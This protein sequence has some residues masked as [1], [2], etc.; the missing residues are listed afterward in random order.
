MKK[1]IL[2]FILLFTILL[3]SLPTYAVELP[4]GYLKYGSRGSRVEEV[5][6]ALNKIGYQIHEDGIYGKRT[7]ESI[8]DLQRKYNRLSM[9]GIYGANT[10]RAIEK[11]MTG[12]DL[13]TTDK[14]EEDKSSENIEPASG[15]IAYL[16]FDDGPSTTV[17]PEILDILN[18][19]DI[20]ATFFVLGT[21]AEQN[22][23]ILKRIQ[24][25]GHSIGNHTYSHKYDYLYRNMDNF[26]GELNK[27]DRILK[28]ILG[29]DFKT[30]LLRFPGGS[31]ENYK[32]KYKDKAESLGYRVYDWNA[33]NGDSES[34]GRSVESLI[35]RLK[36]TSRGQKE[37][38]VLMHDTYGK[39]NTA[40]ALPSIIDYL[41]AEGYGFGKL[42]E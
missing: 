10:R 7:R 32:Q 30:R 34:S 28:G 39:E 27:T 9:D 19:Y 21:M 5:Q 24:E 15:K 2:S 12:E 13:A 38:V 17:T 22:P 33:L 8:L 3:V 31:F 40:K 29:E 18:K 37:L 16:T 36:E 35:G 6:R 4:G 14:V 20:R 42:E 25:E 23:D 1:K 11:L 41:K 26:L